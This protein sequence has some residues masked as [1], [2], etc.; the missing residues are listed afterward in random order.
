MIYFE[1]TKKN[2]FDFERGIEMNI[3]YHVIKDFERADQSLIDS[4]TGVPVPNIGDAM[5]RTAAISSAIRPMNHTRLQGSAYTVRAQAGDNLL[6]YYAID[7]AKP[8][9]V[10]VVDGN[11]FTER[12]LIGGIMSEFAKAKGIAG[13]VIDGAVR[14]PRDLEG[15]D[16]PVFARAISPNGPYKNGPGEI[17]VPVNI[18]GKIVK[19]GDILIGDEDGLVV[20]DPKNALE[21]SIKAHEVMKKEEKMVQSIRENGQL[22]IN[23]VYKKLKADGCT[24][25]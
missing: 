20:I 8:G 9:D 7:N 24:F 25:E 4:F 14:D 19:P 10:I 22:D 6:I 15:M 16:F 2:A 1:R 5:N 23:W 17:N 13:I 11:G 21:I 18:G 12:A 3:G